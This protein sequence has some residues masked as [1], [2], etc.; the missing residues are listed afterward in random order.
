MRLRKFDPTTLNR[1]GADTGTQYRSAIFY[2]NDEQ[3]EIAK[4]AILE[5]EK[6]GT[7]KSPVVTT[8]ERLAE[9]FEAEDYHQDF[10]TKNPSN[11]YCQISISPKLAKLEKIIKHVAPLIPQVAISLTCG[12][13]R[14]ICRH[15]PGSGD[16]VNQLLGGLALT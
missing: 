5:T 15:L 6:K 3:L 7:W 9:F 12:P 10:F 14:C 11:R 16:S 8:L 2:N 4:I 13:L 1:Q